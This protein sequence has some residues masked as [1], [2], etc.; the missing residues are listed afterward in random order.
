MDILYKRDHVEY[1]DG[2]NANVFKEYNLEDPGLGPGIL[3]LIGNV[4]AALST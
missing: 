2:L 4:C 1:H 3:Y